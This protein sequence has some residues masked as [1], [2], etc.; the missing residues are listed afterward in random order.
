MKFFFKNSIAIIFL[1]LVGLMFVGCDKINDDKFV[2][3][4]VPNNYKYG[5]VSGE[6][7]YNKGIQVKISATPNHEYK[8][9]SWSDGVIDNPRTVIV[10]E[11]K[12]YTAI[13]VEKEKYT[14]SLN[15]NDGRFGDITINN[16]N[17]STLTTFEGEEVSLV[18]K[19]KEDCRFTGWSDGETS[20]TRTIIMDKDYNLTANFVIGNLIEV[21]GH[22]VTIINAKADI[23]SDKLILNATKKV[24]F[25][26]WSSSQFDEN[27]MLGIQSSLEIDISDINEDI[28]FT[29]NN[30]FDNWF[31]GLTTSEEEIFDD[32]VILYNSNFL[33]NWVEYSTEVSSNITYFPNYIQGSKIKMYGDADYYTKILINYLLDSPYNI[34][35]IKYRY[36]AK[37]FHTVD[38]TKYVKYYYKKEFNT[39]E[40]NTDRDKKEIVTY[41]DITISIVYDYRLK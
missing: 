32:K 7:I 38:G 18:A 26:Y 35:D 34:L 3:Y 22:N 6:G 11:V 41:D 2:M 1:L 16:K 27:Y 25:G 29:A 24:N 36:D 14:I 5:Q 33:S 13:F 37:V 28:T 8:F 4:V 31:F 9:K 39:S 10:G 21:N 30:T 23:S 12:T 17:L 19:P 40:I 20:E 15:I